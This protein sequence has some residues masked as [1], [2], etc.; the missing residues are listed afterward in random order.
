MQATVDTS[1]FQRGT[2][3]ISLSQALDFQMTQT[4]VPFKSPFAGG[5]AIAMVE[6][7]WI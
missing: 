1:G 6:A 7:T 4:G 5:T 2:S 3:T